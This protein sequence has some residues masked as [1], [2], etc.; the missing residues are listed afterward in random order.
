MRR[1]AFIAGLGAA[2]ATPAVAQAFDD[3]ADLIVTAAKI[4]TVDPRVPQAEALVVRRGRVVYAGTRA[5]AMGY[6]RAGTQIIDYRNAT[7]L[8][9]LIDAHQ[10]LMQVGLAMQE[11]DLF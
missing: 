3:R 8:P 1:K 6:R 7:I 9:G 11:V 4:H 2:A 10:H 5:T